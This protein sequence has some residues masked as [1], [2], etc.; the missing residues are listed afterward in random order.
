MDITDPPYEL[1]R[2]RAEI[3]S[4]RAEITGLRNLLMGFQ[5]K[6]DEIVRDHSD[7]IKSLQYEASQDAALIAPLESEIASLRAQ[8]ELTHTSYVEEN[9]RLMA[10]REA[11]RA[12]LAEAQGSAKL[13]GLMCDLG[14]AN[15]DTWRDETLRLRTELAAAK[16]E[17]NDAEEARN[18]A[19]TRLL[20]SL[21]TGQDAEEIARFWP[22]LE[23]LVAKLTAVEADESF[24]GI[25]GLLHAHGYQYSGPDWRDDLAIAR[26]ALACRTARNRPLPETRCDC[27]D[28]GLDD[29][30]EFCPFC[31][32]QHPD[33]ANALACRP[34]ADGR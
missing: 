6:H 11:L 25:W 13:N 22:A 33:A 8:N 27:C 23:C 30:W 17:L 24:Q 10:E 9:N 16:R 4:L 34:Q 2:A 26:A 7:W 32:Q 18:D 5:A 28:N 12:E 19:E 3:A 1:D 31:G 29:A 21:S 14:F 15:L 20:D